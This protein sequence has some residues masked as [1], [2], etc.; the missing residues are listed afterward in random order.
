M[1]SR[2]L[3]AIP[4]LSGASAISKLSLKC[5]RCRSLMSKDYKYCTLCGN[6]LRCCPIVRNGKSSSPVIV[7]VLRRAE[8]LYIKLQK[9]VRHSV[10][11]SCIEANAEF[12]YLD[13]VIVQDLNRLVK[14]PRCSGYK[15]KELSLYSQL[16]LVQSV[17]SAQVAFLSHS[18][19]SEELKKLKVS[20][21]ER[22]PSVSSS[23]RNE[24][25]LAD[26][27]SV[28]RLYCDREKRSRLYATSS[29][30]LKDFGE[31]DVVGKETQGSEIHSEQKAWLFS[32]FNAETEDAFTTPIPSNDGDKSGAVLFWGD[33]SE[34]DGVKNMK[35]QVPSFTDT[36]VLNRCVVENPPKVDTLEDDV[37]W[38][39]V[40][41]GQL[42]SSHSHKYTVHLLTGKTLMDL[43]HEMKSLLP[44]LDID[45]RKDPSAFSSLVS[46]SLAEVIERAACSLEYYN[47]R[48]E[49]EV[50]NLLSQ[51]QAEL[52]LRRSSLAAHL[53][54]AFQFLSKLEKT[55]RQSYESEKE[56]VESTLLRYGVSE[57]KQRNPLLIQKLLNDD[58][59][60]KEIVNKANHDIEVVGRKLKLLIQLES[61]L[62]NQMREEQFIMN[63][64]ISHW[65]PRLSEIAS[66]LTQSV[67]RAEKWLVCSSSTSPTR[68][69]PSL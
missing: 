56:R 16:H 7:D 30:E 36:T 52:Q 67:R 39:T 4:V 3:P 8:P 54:M 47:I 57:T 12:E 51:Y 55:S 48:F 35:D 59:G 29:C 32:S 40:E 53:A 33:L 43:Y 6:Q 18:L 28:F 17:N 66:K 25:Y 46:A 26:H 1:T 65:M 15:E 44:L 69:L 50:N 23:K 34:E 5:F 13:P 24:D 37:N 19:Q 42:I 14:N 68:F 27:P 11:E 20:E 38:L 58:D 10:V 21:Q 45:F 64:T 41:E 9:E 31:G 63:E 22:F 62:T 60:L 49:E 61:D 2:T